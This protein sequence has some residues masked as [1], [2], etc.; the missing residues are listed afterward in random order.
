M[1]VFDLSDLGSSDVALVR[2]ELARLEL[3]PFFVNSSRLR[4]LLRYLYEE[5]WAGRREDISQYTIAFECFGQNSGFDT[6]VN[7]LVRSHAHRLRKVLKELARPDGPF[8]ILMAERGYGLIVEM[9]ADRSGDTP[10]GFQRATVG[11]MEP[12]SRDDVDANFL[13]AK[14]ITHSLMDAMVGE[15]DLF[16][17]SILWHQHTS[18][19]SSMLNQAD[20]PDFLL[21]GE[22]FRQGGKSC[23]H[24]S[25]LE[26]PGGRCLWTTRKEC[27]PAATDPTAVKTLAN[28]LVSQISGDWGVICRNVAKQA[29]KKSAADFQAHEAV[30]VARQY[31]THFHYEHLDGCVRSLRR[32]ADVDEAG[33][34]ATLAVVLSMA[35]AV[36]PRWKEPLD[37]DEIRQLAARAARLDPDSGW[38]RLALGV[39]AMIDGRCFELV[40]MAKRAECEDDTPMMLLG[41]L[42]TLLCFQAREIELGQRMIR[43]YIQGSSGYPRLVHLALAQCALVAGDTVTA[44]RELA[45]YGVPWG[46]ASPLVS[47]GCS[48]IEGDAGAA[49]TDWQRVIDAFPDFSSRWKE[50]VATQWDATHLEGILRSLEAVGIQTGCL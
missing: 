31:L 41:A 42:G 20:R 46:W 28:H 14:Q 13:F 34:P 23:L 40:E 4:Q 33:I 26:T 45:N 3:H 32:A 19:P 15:S 43:R 27:D 2:A 16:A 24:F 22:I 29:R 8:R 47:A 17:P 44:R 30:A 1:R 12:I 21:Y 9:I 35:C 39:S 7:T 18:D 48:A 25:L 37:R 10:S 49:R 6:A 36:E 5:S 38:T 50:T 11:I